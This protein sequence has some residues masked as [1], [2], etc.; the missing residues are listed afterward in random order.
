MCVVAQDIAV[1]GWAITM[2]SKENAGWQA[3][4]NTV[5]QNLGI[6]LSYIGFMVLTSEDLWSVYLFIKPKACLMMLLLLLLLLATTMSG[7]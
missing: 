4:C 1:D 3:T 6:F 2:L 5:G 7:P